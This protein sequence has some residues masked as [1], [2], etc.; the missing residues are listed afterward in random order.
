M[1]VS[2]RPRRT[3]S[4]TISTEVTAVPPDVADALEIEHDTPVVAIRRLRT[5]DGLPLGLQTA[6]LPAER[7]PGLEDE[8]LQDRS[9]YAV[10]REKYGVTPVEAI[11]TFRVAR[12][13]KPD[14]ALLEVSAGDCAFAVERITSDTHRPFE[15]V[16]SI[17]RGDH[18]QVRLAL[19]NPNG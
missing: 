6:Y 14:A 12:V 9:L 8:T 3:G 1:D 2:I 5:G 4:R 18:Y 7:F 10:L 15:C 17:M 11:E 19:R 13:A 16:R